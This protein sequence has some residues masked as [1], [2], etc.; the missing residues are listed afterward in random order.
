MGLSLLLTL[1]ENLLMATHPPSSV[2]TR[3]ALLATLAGGGAAGWWLQNSAVPAG[4]GGKGN[5]KNQSSRKA[6]A[7]AFR[8]IRSVP[9]TRTD[10]R[11][12]LSEQLPVM[13]DIDASTRFS[14]W[15]SLENQRL[16]QHGKPGRHRVTPS[17]EGLRVGSQNWPCAQLDFVPEVSPGVGWQGAVYRGRLRVIR[18]SAHSLMLLN[19]VPLED[20]LAS[21][22]DAE[23]PAAFPVAA[24]QAQAIIARSY[25]W[26]RQQMAPRAALFDVFATTRSQ[27]YLGVE[28]TTAAGKRWAGESA[29]SRQI[30]QHTQGVI[31][32]DQG[33]PFTT[34][35]S[36]V[37]GG[38]TVRGTTE[39]AD[40]SPLHQ[41][42]PCDWCQAAT[43]YRWTLRIPRETVNRRFRN[44][45][46]LAACPAETVQ[47]R[48]SH[49]SD[50]NS[51]FTIQM[52]SKKVAVSGQE[53]RSRLGE[54]GIWSP[55][56]SLEI[57]S[58]GLLLNG[59]GHGH[60]VGLC[61]WGAQGQA[62]AGHSAEE[63][64]ETYYPGVTFGRLSWG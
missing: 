39:F 42:V 54:R 26:N 5:S 31:C 20:Y 44:W 1:T 51:A 30:V 22:V 3:R 28:Y 4:P 53:L 33:Q 55:R 25:A 37:C 52:G 64:L 38:Q 16:L 49:Q 36:A 43:R 48:T 9:A 12:R 34:Y 2:W 11:V 18:V 24:R 50:E 23:M 14:L 40:A 63:I 7:E 57:T 61:Q 17:G 46:K 13:V 8:G 62:L 6:P 19:V 21:V 47:V 56:F 15:N 29:A 32:L 41:S 58:D 35:Y 27:R 45:R 59:R 60:G 10:L